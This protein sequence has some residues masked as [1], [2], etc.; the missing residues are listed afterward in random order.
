MKTINI[1][2]PERNLDFADEIVT[3]SHIR[4][5]RRTTRKYDSRSDF[6]RVALEELILKEQRACENASAQEQIMELK[7]EKNET[8]NRP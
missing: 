7:R 4:E 3:E 1:K 6:I 5:G 8:Q 2:L